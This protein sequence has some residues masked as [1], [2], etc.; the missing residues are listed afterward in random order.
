MSIAIA[1]VLASFVSPPSSQDWLERI[2]VEA[3]LPALGAAAFVD[4]VPV[5]L[6][7]TGE[8]A[9][10]SA[11]RVEPSDQWHLGSCAKAMT[12]TVLGQ[13]VARDILGWGDTIGERLGDLEM[14][15]AWEGV[16]LSD[17]VRHRSGLPEDRT[18]DPALF[19]RIRALEGPLDRQRREVVSMVLGKPPATPRGER[20]AYSNFGYVIAAAMAEARTGQT[21][22]DLCRR[23]LFEPL[24]MTSA[25]FGPPGSGEEVD[26]PRGHR[27]ETPLAP[28]P[29]A[30]NPAML[31]PA[32]TVSASLEDWGRFLAWHA[33]D[34][35]PLVPTTRASL[36]DP[37]VVGNYAGGWMVLERPWANGTVLTHSGSNSLWFASCWVA[38]R[39][40]WVVMAVTNS[41]VSSAPVAC[42]RAIVQLVR[43]L[44]A[45][46]PGEG[47]QPSGRPGDAAGDDR[48]NRPETAAPQ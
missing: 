2:R 20:M 36:H 23:E 39:R 43:R 34:D 22:E 40:G 45:A 26:S 18:A 6:E 32:G 46:G 35:G 25:R 44:E 47:E 9:L 31:G 42:D 10:G 24:G 37:G 21:W 19:M 33:G 38:P 5:I 30:D 41:G 3:G 12:A 16:T 28:G 29:W 48:V 11:V 1:L 8:R 17:L 4:G 15:E 14:D 13:L 7:V 27:G